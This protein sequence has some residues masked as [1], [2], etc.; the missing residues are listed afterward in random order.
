MKIIFFWSKWLKLGFCA[1]INFW[2]CKSAKCRRLYSTLTKCLLNAQSEAF[3]S[4][5]SSLLLITNPV[6]KCVG[7]EFVAWF[8]KQN[9]NQTTHQLVL[10]STDLIVLTLKANFKHIQ[11]LNRGIFCCILSLKK[12]SRPQKSKLPLQISALSQS[13]WLKEKAVADY[14]VNS[15]FNGSQSTLIH[16]NMEFRNTT[17]WQKLKRFWYK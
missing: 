4:S 5:V 1:C 2:V 9:K 7:A 16:P 15:G 12:S 14:H 8:K 17:C 10:V 6:L 3:T 11:N 13:A